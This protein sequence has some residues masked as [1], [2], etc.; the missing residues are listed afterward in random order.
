V[1]REKGATMAISATRVKY[2]D[3]SFHSPV[4]ELSLFKDNSNITSKEF[5]GNTISDLFNF[6]KDSLGSLGIDDLAKGIKSQLNVDAESHIDGLNDLELRETLS[7]TFDEN[8]FR[9][10]IMWLNPSYVDKYSNPYDIIGKEL[11]SKR[12]KAA[13]VRSLNNCYTSLSNKNKSSSSYYDRS[14]LTRELSKIINELF[15]ESCDVVKEVSSVRNDPCLLASNRVNTYTGTRST[16][17]LNNYKSSGVARYPSFSQSEIQAGYSPTFNL[18]LDPATGS[19]IGS[20]PPIYT[21]SPPR[22]IRQDPVT[23]QWKAYGI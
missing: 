21:D 8:Q 1:V 22:G 4:A 14:L 2:L 17:S 19:V 13:L 23:G 9:D 3:Q 10:L 20:G 18:I 6:V 7:S 5:I 12:L 16:E 15:G 11:D